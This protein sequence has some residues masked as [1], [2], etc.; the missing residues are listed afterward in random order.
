MPRNVVVDA[1]F[2][3]DKAAGLGKAIKCRTCF[4]CFILFLNFF[5]Y[6]DQQMHKYFTNYHTPTYFETLVSS[7][8]SIQSIPCKVTQVF[9]MQLLVIQFTIRMFHI[10]FMQVLIL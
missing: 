4:L 10:G 8:G 9:Q 3:C 6:Y 1:G 2:L 5:L 7:S